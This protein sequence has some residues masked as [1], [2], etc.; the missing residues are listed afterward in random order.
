MADTTVQALIGMRAL[1]GLAA[2]EIGVVDSEHPA[3]AGYLGSGKLAIINEPSGR[4]RPQPE[5]VEEIVI[6][7][8][9]EG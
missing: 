5:P 3:F 6:E 4:R 9:P 2:G 8:P 1:F 7:T